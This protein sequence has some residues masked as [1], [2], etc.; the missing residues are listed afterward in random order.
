ML[1]L[2]LWPRSQHVVQKKELLHSDCIQMFELSKVDE[3]LKRF[4][5]LVFA[6]SMYLLCLIEPL[7]RRYNLLFH[8]IMFIGHIVI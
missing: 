5:E 3:V 7:I 6:F 1:W 8:F 4:Q 2:V